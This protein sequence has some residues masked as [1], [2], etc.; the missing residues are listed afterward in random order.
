MSAKSSAGNA[1]ELT[2]FKSSYST[3]DGPACVEV[4]ETASAIHVRDSKNIPGPHL[5]FTPDAWAEFV[6]YASDN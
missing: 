6:T 5:G 1:S 2:W 4:A 3:N